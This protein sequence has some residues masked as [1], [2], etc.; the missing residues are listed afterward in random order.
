[1]RFDSSLTANFSVND[2]DH[3]LSRRYY[4]RRLSHLKVISILQHNRRLN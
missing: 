3:G 1:M 2:F 4:N